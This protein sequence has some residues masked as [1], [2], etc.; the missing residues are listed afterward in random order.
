M[1]SNW[2]KRLDDAVFSIELIENEPDE[3][4]LNEAQKSA[5]E[6]S[7]TMQY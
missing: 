6:L 7:K 5:E 4:L 1:V 2:E 3:E